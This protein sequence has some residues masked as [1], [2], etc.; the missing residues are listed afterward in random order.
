MQIIQINYYRFRVDSKMDGKVLLYL[1]SNV[2]QVMSM[3]FWQYTLSKGIMVQCLPP[4]LYGIITSE[5]ISIF[6][7]LQP[8]VLQ[9]VW[10]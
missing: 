4:N 2:A 6:Q 7:K 3:Y 10:K 8:A 1:S 9:T 5:K